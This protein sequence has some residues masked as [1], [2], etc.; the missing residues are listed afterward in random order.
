MVSFEMDGI[1]YRCFDH[2]YAVSRCG[3]ALRQM[4]PYTPAKHPMGYLT[5][6][7]RRLMHRVVATCWVE[8]PVG[9]TLVHHINGD[10]ADNRAANLEWVTPKDHVNERH[11]GIHGK[12]VRTQDTRAKIS[13]FR[14]GRK[15]SEA[16]RAL[17]AAVLLA[18]CPKRQITF[19]GITYPSV[20]AAARAAG[21][22]LSTFRLWHLSK[23]FPD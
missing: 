19:Q 5:L 20:S 14:T 6:G 15:D 22:P 10:K 7:R 17:K 2:L 23:S 11:H 1:E 21:L 13:A 16:T 4:R 12:H 3:K 8:R 9:S 18:V